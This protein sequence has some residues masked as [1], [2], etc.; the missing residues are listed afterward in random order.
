MPYLCPDMRLVV[1][2]VVGLYGLYAQQCASCTVSGSPILPRGFDPDSII[3]TAGQDTEVVIQF[4]LP[5]TV[6]EFGADLYP[7]YAIY[8]DSLRMAGRD[9]YVVVK[10]TTSTLVSYGN[11]A[12]AFDQAPR[13]KEVRS[14]VTARVVV[15]R[16]PSPNEAQAQAG[17][18]SPPRGCVR[19]CIKGVRATPSGTAD[20]LYIFLRAFIDP[21]SINVSPNGV[22]SQDISEKDTT[23]LMP[24]LNIGGSRFDLYSDTSLYY[25]PVIVQSRSTAIES[26]V[27]GGIVLSPNPTWGVAMVRFTTTYSV[28]VRV[29]ALDASGRVVHERDMGVLFPGEH[30]A[31]LQLPAGIYI[32]ELLAGKES[33]KARLV[34]LE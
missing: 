20:S 9:T 18:P 29:R 19:A 28:P 15:Y 17:Q 32:V 24:T 27:R 14:G 6:R 22:T 8:V 23:N 7:N 34:V 30:T 2:L 21:R 26:A 12:F 13:S 10:G 16:N 3:L 1:G 11:G 25:G 31:D 4:T 5:D 33:Y